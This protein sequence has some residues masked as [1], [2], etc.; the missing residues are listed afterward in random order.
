MPALNMIAEGQRSKMKRA[1]RIL[2]RV[3]LLEVGNGTTKI[4][5]LLHVNCGLKPAE[6]SALKALGPSI[7]YATNKLRLFKSFHYFMNRWHLWHAVNKHLGYSS[8]SIGVNDLMCNPPYLSAPGET[9]ALEITNK[10]TDQELSLL[11]LKDPHAAMI[12]P[13]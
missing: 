7:S 2:R 9:L 4:E 11:V 12:G 8:H 1:H 6:A 13:A 3:E 5:N 10:C